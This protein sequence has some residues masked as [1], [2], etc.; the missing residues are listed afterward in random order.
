MT[1]HSLTVGVTTINQPIVLGSGSALLGFGSA[2]CTLQTTGDFPAVI[3]NGSG[4]KAEG[5]GI[6]QHMP[7]QVRTQAGVQMEQPG[8]N[9]SLKDIVVDGYYMGFDLM[10]TAYGII[11]DCVAQD[12]Q[13]HGFRFRNS[14]GCAAMQ[15]NLLNC[16]ALRNGGYGFRMMAAADAYAT[17]GLWTNVSTFA[18]SEGGFLFEAI[19]GSLNDVRI[20]GINA[21]TDGGHEV[22][23]NTRGE[24][25]QI[26]GGLIEGAGTG[27]TGPGM[28]TTPSHAGG[29]V[30]LQGSNIDVALA[31]LSIRANSHDGIGVGGEEGSCQRLTATGCLISANNQANVGLGGVTIGDAG[32][33]ATFAACQSWGEPQ[34]HGLWAENTANLYAAGCLFLP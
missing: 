31:G 12:C 7:V 5:F 3:L 2:V 1:V 11:Q 6:S 20:I 32:C 4:I 17:S 16:L 8:M 27:N 24:H 29:G 26:I 33:V 22:C 34:H 23:F 9:I 28:A 13:V 19:A 15:W 10:G 21:S 25:N 14:D 30:V 18:N